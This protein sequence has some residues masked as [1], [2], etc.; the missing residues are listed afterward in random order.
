MEHSVMNELSTGMYVPGTVFLHVRKDPR[1]VQFK[2]RVRLYIVDAS[3]QGC[4]LSFLF[5]YCWHA[6]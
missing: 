6:F 2:R 4:P 5:I 1:F 3:C